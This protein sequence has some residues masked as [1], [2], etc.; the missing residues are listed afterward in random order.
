MALFAKKESYIG[1]DIGAH[2]M[3]MVELK[4]TKGRAQLWT[5]GIADEMLDIHIKEKKAKV[6]PEDMMIEGGGERLDRSGP[7]S[8]LFTG[9][10]DPR[11]K[12]YGHMLKA[13]WKQS[14]VSSNQA[15]A[16]LPVSQVFHAVITLPEVDEKEI[17][18]HVKAKVKKMLPRPIEQMQ[19]VHQ[20]I[21]GQGEKNK[22]ISLLVTAAPKALINFYTTIFQAAGLQLVDLETEAF[23]LE[24]SLIGKDKATSMIVDIGAER[25]N[26]FIIDQ[27]LPIT[28][29]SIQTGGDTIDMLLTDKLGM[30]NKEI[31]QIKSDISRMP[32]NEIEQLQS[33]FSP[34][35]E[36]IIKEIDYSFNLFL[37]QIGNEEKKP[38]KI[39]LTGGSCVFP[40]FE[41][42]IKDNFPMRV[43]IGDPWARVVYQQ[44]LKKILDSIGPR[45]SVA[46]GLAMRNI[47]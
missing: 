10:N 39:V 19:V 40:F 29:R 35:I 7:E 32:V 27:G 12:K 22:N 9:E 1:V 20:V 30:D 47:V 42:E 2:G 13:L 3:K 33:I 14:K 44:R 46:I 45:M 26:F 38:E 15:S 31:M 34:V 18:H 6:P 4:K 24:R 43:F 28:H 8:G 41:H 5:Y 25:T 17:D 21:P 23:A 11:V 16:S 37:N 36:P